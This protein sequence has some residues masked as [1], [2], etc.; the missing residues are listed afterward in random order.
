MKLVVGLG[1]PKKEYENTRHNLGFMVLDNIARRQGFSFKN[2]AQNQA[3]IAEVSE[4]P[5]K[6]IF[7]KPQSFMNN[8]GDVVA[9]VKNYYKIN[10]ED[11]WVI[12]DDVDL[13]FGKV[14]VNLDGSSAGHKG[15]S[16][17]IEKIGDHFW[18]VRI[19]VGKD[20]KIATDKWVLQKFTKAENEKLPKIID[21]VAELVI[22]SLGNDLIVET[23][24][25]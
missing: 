1:N 3:L 15:V 12:G 21:K 9:K 10:T 11:I 22:E 16:S 5:A 2:N 19:G 7:I 18:R 24:N 8:S 13:E 17:I 23:I 20:E 14:R 4:M 25:I 6:V